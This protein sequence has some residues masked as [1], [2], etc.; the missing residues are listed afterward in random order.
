MREGRLQR[1]SQFIFAERRERREGDA[2]LERSTVEMRIFHYVWQGECESDKVRRVRHPRTLSRGSI[3]R[4]IAAVRLLSRFIIPG[5]NF[6]AHT[7]D[8][9]VFAVLG[10]DRSPRH[11]FLGAEAAHEFIR[12]LRSERH[13]D[14]GASIAISRLS[15]GR[16]QVDKDDERGHDGFQAAGTAPMDRTEPQAGAPDQ[17]TVSPNRTR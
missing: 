16:A 10:S 2:R 8:L 1:G 12:C 15:R 11:H 7:C 3:G 4:R 5:D 9:E 14:R 6:A 13:I 17:M